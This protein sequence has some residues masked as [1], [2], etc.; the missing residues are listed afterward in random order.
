MICGLS[1]KLRGPICDKFNVTVT[2]FVIDKEYV[3]K[4]GPL[5]Y[6]ETECLMCSIV[7]YMSD[8]LITKSV[9]I[10]HLQY[11]ACIHALRLYL[12][13]GLQITAT[14]T[15]LAQST[16]NLSQSSQISELLLECQK[17]FRS[18]RFRCLSF[19]LEIFSLAYLHKFCF[20]FHQPSPDFCFFFALIEYSSN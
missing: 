9:S 15:Q 6:L 5:S 8:I 13:I 2:L 12:T 14:N 10:T 17:Y 11:L 18:Q 3:H 7:G 20:G 1:H 19:K 16:T 4:T